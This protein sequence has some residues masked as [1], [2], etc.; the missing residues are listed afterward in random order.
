MPYQKEGNMRTIKFRAWDNTRQ[1]MWL[2]EELTEIFLYHDIGSVAYLF[3]FA[4]DKVT[5]FELM[6]YT[7]L[8]DKDTKDVY[9]GDIIKVDG[10]YW[11]AYWSLG[12]WFAT[13][14]KVK[15]VNDPLLVTLASKGH[16]VGNMYENPGLL[17]GGK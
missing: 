10:T 14:L 9:D 8:K 11:E 15:N 16:V 12:S 1:T 7:G 5:D 4:M 6:Q 3:N 17:E 13:K 2:A